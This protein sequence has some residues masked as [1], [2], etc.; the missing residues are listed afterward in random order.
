[1][2]V[3]RARSPELFWLGRVDEARA[4]LFTKSVRFSFTLVQ[5][6]VARLPRW[7]GE[8]TKCRPAPLA[9]RAID[10]EK[11]WNMTPQSRNACSASA[12]ER[13][14]GESGKNAPYI[15]SRHLTQ[16]LFFSRK[17]GRAGS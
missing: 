9:R 8:R 7:P 10:F 14:E 1:M 17:R 6:R 12:S 15:F 16:V 5:R 11:N 13:R 2:E 3:V 4:V